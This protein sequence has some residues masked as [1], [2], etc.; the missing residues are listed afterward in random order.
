MKTQEHKQK[1]H[2][3]VLI[4]ILNSAINT[5]DKEQ[6]PEALKMI[7]SIKLEVYDK[8][9]NPIQIQISRRGFL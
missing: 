4:V 7:V 5:V 6:V 8:M 1:L 2:P 9:F 3:F